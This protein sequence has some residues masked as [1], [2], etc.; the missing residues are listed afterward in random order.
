MKIIILGAGHVGSTLVEHLLS[1]RNDITLI[2][3]DATRLKQVSERFDLRTIHGNATYPDVL[4]SADAENADMIIA[5]TTFD[6]INMLACQIAHYLFKTPMKIARVRAQEYMHYPQL[7]NT[8]ALAIDVLIN[9]EHLLT[10]YIQRLIEYP[11]ALQVLD[12]ANGHIELVSIQALKGAPIV[13]YPL[14]LMHVH[15]PSVEAKIVAI[16]RAG[17]TINPTPDT[18]IE[19]D[20]EVF[21]IAAKNNVREVNSE[22]RGIDKP[23]RSIMIAGGGNIGLGLAQ[24]L[25]SHYQVK[26]IN[27]GAKRCR[28]IAEKLHKSIVLQG[29]AADENLL[30]NENISEVDVFCAL[31]NDDEANIMSATLAKRMG[32]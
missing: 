19:A 16:S 31:T 26:V 27:R 21:F 10:H 18:V 11:G 6:E 2:D 8:K 28:I 13:G 4:E 7:F 9:P 20:D 1:E 24:I 15:M 12:F 32:A 22:L 5:V 17:L 14:S 3:I 23:N 25:E 29:N 30:L